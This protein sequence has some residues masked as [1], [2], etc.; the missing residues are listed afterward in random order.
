MLSLPLS[1]IA[2]LIQQC[3]WQEAKSL[4]AHWRSQY[5]DEP[6]LKLLEAHLAYAMGNVSEAEAMFREIL[7]SQAPASVWAE[8]RQG[9]R[10]IEEDEFKRRQQRAKEI[11]ESSPEQGLGFLALLPVPP[12]NVSLRSRAVERLARI[13]R[14]DLYTAKFKLPTRHLKI[15]RLGAIAELQAHG[16]ELQQAQIPAVWISKQA[17]EQIPLKQVR[18]FEV[19]GLGEV[20]AIH[21]QGDTRFALAEVSARVEGVLPTYGNVF[22]LNAK[23]Q[24]IRREQ[25]LDRVRICDFHLPQRQLILRF[26]DSNYQ[27]SQGVQVPVSQ[28]L[29]NLKPTVHQRWQALM[30]WFASAMPHSRIYDHFSHFQDML[31]MYPDFVKE[32]TPRIELCRPKPQLVDNCFEIYSATLFLIQQRGLAL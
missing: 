13:L 17:I 11:A 32:I 23:Y 25:M 29:P 1:E 4:L 9:L 24:I 8:A 30:T 16:E 7:K 14:T 3:Q 22:D 26:H 19:L 31:M 20:R 2:Q 21:H 10:Q 28:P 5:P 18:Y 12:E 15:I 27:F 6:Q